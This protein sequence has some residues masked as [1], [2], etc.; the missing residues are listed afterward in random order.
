MQ[1][2]R[3]DRAQID[4]TWVCLEIQCVSVK[5]DLCQFWAAGMSLCRTN[6]LAMVL[7]GAALPFVLLEL[8]HLKSIWAWFCIAWDRK[9]YRY[10]LWQYLKPPKT[11]HSAFCK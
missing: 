1:I 3:L 6:K 5:R 8:V 2:C 9:T 11:E 4:N 7:G 10:F